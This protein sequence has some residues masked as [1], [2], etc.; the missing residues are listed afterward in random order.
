MAEELCPG[1]F[2][3]DER[4]ELKDVTEKMHK[5]LDLRHYSRSDF[6]VSPNGIYYLESNTLPG[7]TQTSLM[8]KGFSAVGVSFEEF[9][10]HINQTH[11]RGEEGIDSAKLTN[12]RFTITDKNSAMRAIKIFIT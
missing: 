10:E 5:G 7:L 3:P 4:D 1:N 8:P 2:T 11:S 9:V 12:V 6:R